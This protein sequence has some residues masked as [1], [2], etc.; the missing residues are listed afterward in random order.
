MLSRAADLSKRGSL[1][2]RIESPD[3]LVLLSCFAA[4]VLLVPLR[5]VLDAFPFVPFAAAFVLFMAPGVLLSCWLLAG[6]IS[7]P[8]IVPVGFAISA[9]IF[10]LLGVPV[11]ILHGSI[12][13]YLWVAGATLAA[14]LAA[15]A[16]RTLRRTPSV[17]GVDGGGTDVPSAGWLWAPFALLVGVMAFVPTRRVPNK[18]DDIWIYLSWVRDFASADRLALREP[19]FGERTAAFARVQLDGWLLEQAALSRVSGLDTIEL[20][21]RYFTPAL[22]VVALLVVYALARTP[23]P[24]TPYFHVVG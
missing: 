16:L 6:D 3:V 18:N 19:Y 21:L 24:R 8:A 15:A 11:L 9:G 22:V 10:G 4:A 20:V 1:T 17:E 7:G 14:F 5:G 13:A 23:L 12:E 2:R